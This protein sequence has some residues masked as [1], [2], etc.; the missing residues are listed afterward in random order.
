MVHVPAT[1][2]EHAASHAMLVPD[3]AVAGQFLD[4]L[5]SSS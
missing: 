4:A 3:S 5:R 2:Q 1:H